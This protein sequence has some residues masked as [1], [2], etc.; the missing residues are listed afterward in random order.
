MSY[1]R[2]PP[3][4]SDYLQELLRDHAHDEDPG[5]D[6]W[7]DF[8]H[9]LSAFIRNTTAKMNELH[10]RVEQLESALARA[11]SERAELKSLVVGLGGQVDALQAQASSGQ[12]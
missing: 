11:E 2:P 1:R 3:V 5:G 12:D 6:L 4:L 7:D 8:R 10:G 9:A